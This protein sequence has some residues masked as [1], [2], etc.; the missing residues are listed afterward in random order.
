MDWQ[1][2]AQ[3]ALRKDVPFFVRGAVKKRVEAMA[4]DDGLTS[5]DLSFYLSVK[6]RMAPK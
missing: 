6:E 5:I 1:T 3:A 4:L 2:E